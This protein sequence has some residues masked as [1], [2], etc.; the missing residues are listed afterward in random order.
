MHL[1]EPSG[2][3]KAT[4]NFTFSNSRRLNP[5]KTRH[6]HLYLRQCSAL[7]LAGYS[8]AINILLAK[9]TTSSGQ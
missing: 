7:P 5:N 9:T 1:T 4:I 8:L 2:E 6:S 3:L